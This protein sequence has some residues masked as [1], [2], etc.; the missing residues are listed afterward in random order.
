[1]KILQNVTGLSI[2][3]FGCKLFLFAL[4]LLSLALY[5]CGKK[6]I[7]AHGLKYAK[8]LPKQSTFIPDQRDLGHL[9]V[10]TAQQQIGSPYLWGG[11]APERGFDCSGLVWWVYRRHGIGIPRVTHEQ[12]RAGRG[13]KSFR[14]GDLVF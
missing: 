4:I 10:R 12:K 9:L 6:Q 14:P 7:V 2:I 11:N 3:T 5:G 1:M 13:V 8:P